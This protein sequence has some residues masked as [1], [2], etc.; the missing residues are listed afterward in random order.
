[1][2][3]TKVAVKGAATVF[4]I[5]I[6]SAFFAYLVRLLLARNLSI[7]E[8]GLFYSVF[9]FLGLLSTFKSLGID[10]SLNKFISE[11][12][13]KDQFESIKSSIL[14]AFF[15]QIIT[16]T[17]IIFGIYFIAA[18]LSVNFFKNPN[19]VSLLKLMAIAFYIDSFVS[20]LKFTFQGYKK[21]KYFAGIDLIRM[22]LLLVIIFIG[23]QFNLGLNSP[24]I[25]YLITPLFLIGIFG[26]ILIFK[27]FPNFLKISS[28]FN[29]NLV[30]KLSKYGI[31]LMATQV[32]GIILGHTDIL[33]LTYFSGLSQVA[34]YSI[35]LPLS[36]L[37]IY[38]PR[39]IGGIMIPLTS[40]MW[41]K[42]EKFKIIQGIQSLYKYSMIVII[43]LVLVTIS[44]SSFI[45]EILYGSQYVLAANTLKI[46]VIGMIFAAL[47][48]INIK[49]FAGIGK[50]AITSLLIYVGAIFNLIVNIILI[51]KIGIIGAAISTSISY[52]MM[53][54]ISMIKL[55]KY[56]EIKYPLLIWI[57][58]IIASLIFF[59]IIAFLK[60]N[61]TLNIW[62]ESG[63][64][65]FISGIIYIILLFLFKI[66]NLVEIQ[67]ILKRI[68]K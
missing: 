40:E 67:T 54:M 17:I 18:Y 22:V 10:K 61:L 14:F 6:F 12:K 42:D 68:I 43:P 45:I 52:I 33:M 26:Y 65:L 7:E 21:M 25:A 59:S 64:I 55:K 56:I 41:A 57:K 11:F 20:V 36:K 2:N 23:F 29:K 51:P 34:L 5:S 15:V 28:K 62:I 3:Y 32:G 53:M 58:T 35:A 16:N 63:L 44:Y 47:L 31:F 50:P 37:F 19:A 49:F 38:F 8:F 48:S 13:T 9:S 60:I 24:I 46:L 4:I 1:M 27:V 39:A 66:I 30:K